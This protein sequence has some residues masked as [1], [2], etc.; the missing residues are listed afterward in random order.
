M[1][2]Q[3]MMCSLVLSPGLGVLMLCFCVRLLEVTLQKDR[4]VFISK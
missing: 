3:L 4:A 2:Y 1:S